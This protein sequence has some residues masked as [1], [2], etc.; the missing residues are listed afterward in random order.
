MS[1]EAY[2]INVDMMRHEVLSYVDVEGS[3]ARDLSVNQ[4]R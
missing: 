2:V 4:C 3:V 1:V